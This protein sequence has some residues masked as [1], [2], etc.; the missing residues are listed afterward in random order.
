[1]SGEEVRAAGVSQLPAREREADDLKH[2][3]R[4][5]L[6][7]RPVLAKKEI[8]RRESPGKRGNA[9]HPEHYAGCGLSSCE[10]CDQMGITPPT[11]GHRGK[12]WF[13][14]GEHDADSN[15]KPGPVLG[16]KVSSM[17]A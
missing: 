6:M 14:P 7:F 11:L 12:M 5:K 3:F 17:Q 13:Q 15:S 9:F 16:G 4:S 2:R 8:M 1:V 10:A